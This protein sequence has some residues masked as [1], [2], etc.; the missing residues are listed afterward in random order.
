MKKVT[1]SEFHKKIKLFPVKFP[2]TCKNEEIGK[3]TVNFEL[4][5]KIADRDSKEQK[6]KDRIYEFD[7]HLRFE[8]K[9]FI[10]I[11]KSELELI[12]RYWDSIKRTDSMMHLKDPFDSLVYLALYSDDFTMELS[13]PLNNFLFTNQAEIFKL[14]KIEGPKILANKGVQK[15]IE[16]WIKSKDSASIKKLSECLIASFNPKDMPLKV[17]KPSKK[18]QKEGIK[19]IY[20]YILPRLQLMRQFKDWELLN[21]WE[22]KQ[23]IELI[24]KSD[25]ID[26]EWY[27]NWLRKKNYNVTWRNVIEKD[28]KLRKEFYRFEWIPYEMTQKVLA[29]YLKISVEKLKDILWRKR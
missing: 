21:N 1:I 13:A 23:V 2:I 24:E 4:S 25:D 12:D 16:H 17:G 10:E 19:E 15:K 6:L 8:I 26:K 14:I 5:P 22:R 11:I 27:K 9:H 7:W 20:D 3:L 29:K 28:S 18:F